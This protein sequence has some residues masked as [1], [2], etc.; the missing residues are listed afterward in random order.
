MQYNNKVVKFKLTLLHNN[1]E[2]NLISNLTFNVTDG[3]K[4][5]FLYELFQSKYFNGCKKIVLFR[6]DLT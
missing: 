6:H 5:H 1:T 2:L 4:Y 3:N